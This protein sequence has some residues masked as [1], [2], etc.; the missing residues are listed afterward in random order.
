LNS[1]SFQGTIL[2]GAILTGSDI[3]VDDLNTANYCGATMSSGFAADNA[4]CKNN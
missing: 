2:N 4:T 1:P 3:S